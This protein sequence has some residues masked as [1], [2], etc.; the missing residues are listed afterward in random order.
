MLASL[1]TKQYSVQAR[2]HCPPGY[3]FTIKE[4]G[5]IDDTPFLNNLKIKEGARIMVTLNVNTTDGLVNGSFGTIIKVVLS[6]G[7]VNHL[8]VKFDNPK[9]GAKQ[10]SSHP[11][12]AGPYKSVNGTPLFKQNLR[13]RPPKAGGKKHHA[14]VSVLQFPL[15][16]SWA[17]TA[18]KIQGQSFKAGSKIVIHWH[19]W[20]PRAMAYVMCS[21]CQLLEDMYIAGKFDPKKIKC[22]QTALNEAN[23]LEKIHRFVFIDVVL[24]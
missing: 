20:L 1:D 23:R 5:C 10:R 18:H 14:E 22:I 9:F 19:K 17:N 15:K 21:R 3:K 7:Q 4:D 2:C 13:Y 8:I 24:D 11:V 6:N 16:L 12:Q